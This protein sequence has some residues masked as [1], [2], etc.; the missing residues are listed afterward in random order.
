M[1]LH[2]SSSIVRKIKVLHEENNTPVKVFAI[3]LKKSH[4]NPQIPRGRL[5][6]VERKRG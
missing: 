1:I 3:F 4:F 5:V 6:L 2:G